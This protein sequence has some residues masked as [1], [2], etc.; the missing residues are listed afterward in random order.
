MKCIINTFGKTG[1]GSFL[2]RNWGIN[3]LQKSCY[4]GFFSNPYTYE[5]PSRP[6]VWNACLQRIEEGGFEDEFDRST[7]SIHK[8]ELVGTSIVIVYILVPNRVGVFWYTYFSQGCFIS[9]YV[10]FAVRCY[11]DFC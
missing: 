7:T 2:T 3:V 6:S 10:A 5:D 4:G 11:L 8:W 1:M 9:F